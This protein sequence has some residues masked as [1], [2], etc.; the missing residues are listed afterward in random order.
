MVVTLVGR[1]DMMQWEFDKSFPLKF[2]KREAEEKQRRV[3]HHI[4]LYSSEQSHR[5][6][7]PRVVPST[8][9][10]PFG[11]FHCLSATLFFVALCTRKTPHEIPRPWGLAR[12]VPI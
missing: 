5:I 1:M 11:S 10:S 8:F 6:E 4:V 12:L 7:R 9:V 3:I 2:Q